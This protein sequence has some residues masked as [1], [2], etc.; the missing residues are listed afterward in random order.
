MNIKERLPSLPGLIVMGVL[1]LGLGVIASKFMGGSSS[2]TGTRVAVK[3]PELSSGAQQ[4]KS[5]F[6]ANCAQCHGVNAGGGDNG[7]PLVHTIYNPGHHA[8]GAFFLATKKGVR[9]HHWKFGNMAPLPML[10]DKE[11]TDIILYVRELQ[12]ANG[13][14]YKPHNM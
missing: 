5:V 6:D 8:D 10:K 14:F 13:I 12:Q 7:P 11:I 4:G 1:A 2:G 9:Q 3:V